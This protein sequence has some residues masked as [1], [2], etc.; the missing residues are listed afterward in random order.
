[1]QS[2]DVLLAALRREELDFFIGDVRAAANDPHLRAE[3]VY[4]CT[5]GWYARRGHPLAGRSRITIDDLRTYPLILSG[6]ADESLM[7]RMASLYGLS[8]P[9]QEHF[10]ASSNDVST[11]L[12]LVTASDAI[13]PATDVAMVSAVRAGSAVHLDVKP[14]LDLALTLGIVEL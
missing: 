13:A 7:M 14:S 3:P 12:T 11:V 8:L 6:Y 4:P 5:F 2:T 1:V 9:V 10:A